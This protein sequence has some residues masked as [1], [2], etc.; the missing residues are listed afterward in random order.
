MKRRRFTQ[1]ESLQQRLASFAEA[2]R[3]EAA[4][5]SPGPERDALLKKARQADTA[6][7][8]DDWARSKGLQAPE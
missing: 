5:L 1:T 2:A 8:L 3:A 6:S 4:T 7:H